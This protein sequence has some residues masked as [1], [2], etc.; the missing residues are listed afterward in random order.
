MSEESLRIMRTRPNHYVIEI[1]EEDHTMGNLLAST[2]Q[3][4]RGV[5]LAYYDLVHPLE[6]KIRV[7]VT[8][9]EGY[10]I[11]EVLK[12]ALNRIKELNEQFRSQLLEALKAKGMELEE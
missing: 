10:D 5:K 8:L 6:R 3:G 7:Y 2:L 4:L 1:P 9:D 11:K 12:E